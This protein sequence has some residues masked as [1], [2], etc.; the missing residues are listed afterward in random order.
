MYL[1]LVSALETREFLLSLKRLI[2]RKGS[3]EKIYSD[4]GTTFVGAARWLRKARCDDKFNQFLAQN[5][6][7]WQFNVSNAPSRGGQI[8]RM[9]GLVKNALN[10]TIG[11]SLL[12][13]ME[14][15]EVPVDVVTT[16]NNRP[17]SYVEDDV[18]LPTLAPYFMMFPHSNILPD[19]EQHHC[20][21][22]DQ[23]KRVKLLLKCKDA[24][25]KRWSSEYL[26]SL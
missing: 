15:E 14:L 6:I 22:A 23:R 18:A 3:P 9:V 13:W 10:K 26:R 2:T 4:N 7:T 25:W 19:L 1:D 21:D 16:L 24:V 20:A 5:K 17:L 11:C 12:S 8:E